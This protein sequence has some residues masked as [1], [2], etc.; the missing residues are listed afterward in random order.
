MQNMYLVNAHFDEEHNCV[1]SNNL[2][3]KMIYINHSDDEG[4]INDNFSI[5][6]LSFD[7]SQ[8]DSKSGKRKQS[9]SNT[10]YIGDVSNADMSS[11]HKE[12]FKAEIE[13]QGKGLKKTNY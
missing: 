13:E 2:N 11:H 4:Y 8:T 7:G 5:S 6:T 9:I 3:K 1:D 12:Y 10:T